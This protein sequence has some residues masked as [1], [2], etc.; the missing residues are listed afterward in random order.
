[1]IFV[2]F[3]IFIYD[4]LYDVRLAYYEVVDLMLLD[5]LET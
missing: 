1:M 2:N 4:I 3:F 5:Y